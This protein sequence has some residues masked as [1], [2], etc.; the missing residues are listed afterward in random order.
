MVGRIRDGVLRR[1]CHPHTHILFRRWT[2]KIYNR[3]DTDTTL[4]PKYIRG[5]C[6]RI[7]LHHA[8][9]EGILPQHK[10]HPGLRSLHHGDA[11][12]ETNVHEGVYGRSSHPGVH[13]RRPDAHQIVALGGACA[14]RADTTAGGPPPG[15]RVTR[16][17][18][19]EHHTSRN[20]QFNAQLSKVMRDTRADA[21]VNVATQGVRT[22]TKGLSQ[23]DTISKM[24]ADG[25]ATRITAAGE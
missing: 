2:Q 10:H 5:G 6:V 24:A 22:I 4:L 3:T 25:S 1:R 21:G 16:P 23:D 14:S 11:S 18:R 19:K 8:P 7:V 9:T 20:H 17:A 15:P 12:R 13:I